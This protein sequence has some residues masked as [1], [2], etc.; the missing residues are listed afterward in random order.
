MWQR[1]WQ[2]ITRYGCI[3]KWGIRYTIGIPPKFINLLPIWKRKKKNV[4]KTW[5][6]Y[7]S[8]HGFPR[9]S[10]TAPANQSWIQLGSQPKGRACLCHQSETYSGC[11][12]ADSNIP[13]LMTS[14]PARCWEVWVLMSYSI[15]KIF[16]MAIRC[17]SVFVPANETANLYSWVATL[18]YLQILSKMKFLQLKIAK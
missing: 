12:R 15:P 6:F 3:W 13:A 16:K 1:W 8:F 14:A 10:L 2:F 17:Y 7:G 18:K 5:D 11:P 9:L 4:K